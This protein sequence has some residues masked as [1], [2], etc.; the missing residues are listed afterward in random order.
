MDSWPVILIG[1]LLPG[2]LLIALD[3]YLRKFV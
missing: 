2:V 1:I 3:Y